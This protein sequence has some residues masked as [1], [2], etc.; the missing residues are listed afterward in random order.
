M[1]LEHVDGWIN[2]TTGTPS[3]PWT[4][5]HFLRHAYG[6]VSLAPLDLGGL[7]WSLRL[8]S[9]SLGHVDTRTT[10]RIYVH[11]T[12]SEREI[13]RTRRLGIHGL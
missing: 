13:I 6:S 2:P 7:G 4:T 10:E 11:P 9:E 8:V 5:P 12:R 1:N 3:P